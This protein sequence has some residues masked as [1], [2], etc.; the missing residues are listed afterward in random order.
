MPE[1]PK[2]FSWR[3]IVYVALPSLLL[4]IGAFWL[5]AQFIKP[6]PPDRLIIST[7]G[8][9]GAYQ[10][11]AARYKDV[12]ARYGIT[13]VEKPSAGS[14]ENL[15]RLR[16]PEFEVDAALI[17][18]G[19]ARAGDDDGLVSLGDFYYEPLWIFYREGVI[20]GGHKLLDL[21]GKRL[22]VGGAGGG[23]NHLAMELLAAN[24]IDAT[25]TTLIQEGGLGLVAS[26]RKREVDV[27]FVVGPTQSALVWSLLYTPGVRLMNLV[28]AEAYTRRFPYLARL[29]VPRGAVDLEQDIPPHD[30]NL[31][32]PMATMLVRKDTHPALIGLLMQAASEVH[33]VPGVFQKPGEF[34]RAGHS[35]FPLSPEAERYYKNGKPFL[36]RYLP[37]WAA[38]M[39]ERLVVMLVPL[40][41]VLFPLIRFAPQIYGWRVRSRIYRRYGELKFL[42]NELN[43]NPGRHTRDEWIEKLDGIEKDAGT[44]RTPLAFS[45]MLYTLRAH[46]D[47]VRHSI[48][49]HTS[50]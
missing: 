29:V 32:S 48:L 31:V 42:E 26:L 18:G 15:E 25:N 46:I 12:L 20:G 27:V 17:Q 37:F 22:A 41:A 4:A 1:K 34:P 50:H 36:Q 5:A 45:D 44:I 6:A 13:L 28:R 33:G 49:R 23:S 19:T 40:I 47:L 30:V 3:D 10:I 8:E 24:G 35:E 2:L 14:I 7:G 43:E 39:I 38:T 16:N 21:K 11:F 9:G